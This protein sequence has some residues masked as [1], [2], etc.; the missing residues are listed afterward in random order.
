MSDREDKNTKAARTLPF[1][2]FA[3]IFGL[4]PRNPTREQ[5]LKWVRRFF[6]RLFLIFLVPYVLGA[7]SAPPLWLRIVLTLGVLAWLAGFGHAS[8]EL[9]GSVVAYRICRPRSGFRAAPSRSNRL[10]AQRRIGPNSFQEY[11]DCSNHPAM[12]DASGWSW[13]TEAAES[14]M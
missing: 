10:R 5:A 7:I 1:R 6:V 3:Q 8:I 11:C 4:P 9:R 14:P 2:V 12:S 13:S